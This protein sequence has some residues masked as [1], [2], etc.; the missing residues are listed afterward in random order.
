MDRKDKW[1]QERMIRENE[2]AEAVR[3]RE[4]KLREK[5]RERKKEST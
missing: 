5:R 4:R 2:R 1:S 3:E